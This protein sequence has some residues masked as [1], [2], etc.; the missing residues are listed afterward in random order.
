MSLKMWKGF[1]LRKQDWFRFILFWYARCSYE[2]NIYLF[3]CLCS[4][5]LHTARSWEWS[6]GPE[7]Q[8][9]SQSERRRPCDKPDHWQTETHQSGKIISSFMDVIESCMVCSHFLEIHIFTVQLVK[10]EVT[11]SSGNLL[12]PF[13]A[14]LVF[15]KCRCLLFIR[16]KPFTLNLKFSSK[17]IYLYPLSYFQ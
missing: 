12:I 11:M 3:T 16:L 9:W 10:D 13:A 7:Y 17:I 2:K 6:Q 5:Q 15:Q 14:L 8:P 1:Q 4:S